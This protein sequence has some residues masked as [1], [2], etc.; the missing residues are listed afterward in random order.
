[1]SS[2][3]EDEGPKVELL[4][5]PGTMVGWFGKSSSLEDVDR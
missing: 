2:T 3:E 5:M 1:M 4:G